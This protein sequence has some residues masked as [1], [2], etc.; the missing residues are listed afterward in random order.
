MWTAATLAR[1][2]TRS[3]HDDDTRGSHAFPS[4]PLLLPPS[5]SPH[6]TFKIFNNP[7]PVFWYRSKK[8]PC[9]TSPV[10]YRIYSVHR[11]P[12]IIRRVRRL[13]VHRRL[14]LYIVLVSMVRSESCV[15]IV[16]STYL[17]C[18]PCI[19]RKPLQVV[20]F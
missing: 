16:F 10:R 7:S 2:H 5:L 3:P 9:P 4:R 17:L 15:R 14:T 20:A 11:M 18:V 12:V 13:R 8:C 1:S 19:I 6:Y